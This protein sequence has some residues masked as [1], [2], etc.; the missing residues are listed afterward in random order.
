MVQYCKHKT[1]TYYTQKPVC[2]ISSGCKPVHNHT[3]SSPVAL[4]LGGQGSILGRVILKTVEME[5]NASLVGTQHQGLLDCG[6][7][8]NT[9]DS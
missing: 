9:S 5:P 3:Q 6:G 7:E 1:Y 4:R 2:K 8:M